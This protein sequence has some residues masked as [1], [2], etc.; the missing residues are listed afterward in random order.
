MKCKIS[1]RWTRMD[2]DKF[3]DRE[4]SVRQRPGVKEPASLNAILFSYLCPSVSICVHL[5]LI[6]FSIRGL[7]FS[8]CG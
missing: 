4:R 3:R 6:F 8:I 1:H 2:T 7:F 5:W